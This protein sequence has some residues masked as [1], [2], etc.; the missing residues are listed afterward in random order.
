MELNGV[1]AAAV[2]LVRIYNNYGVPAQDMQNARTQAAAILQDAGIDVTWIDCWDKDKEPADV[3]PRCRQPLGPNEIVLRIQAAGPAAGTRYVSM[4]FS[5]VNASS[6]D[7]P[8]LSTVYGDMVTSVAREAGTD[9]RR[10]LGCAIAHEIGHLL[11]NNPRHAEAGLMRATWSHTE[12]RRNAAPD[13]MFL[14]D[15]AQIMRAALAN[16]SAKR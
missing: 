8:V 1:V 3:S 14:D 11:L 5:L 7:K 10:L 16:R 12:L 2:L 13:W 9:T 15:E 6:P 4:G